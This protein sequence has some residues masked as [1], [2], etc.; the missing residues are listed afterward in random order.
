MKAF[1]LKLTDADL[2]VLL[3]ALISA[4]SD[5]QSAMLN[6]SLCTNNTDTIEQFKKNRN[7][8]IEIMSQLEKQKEQQ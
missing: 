6:E 3:D 4:R 1:T 7:S 2:D 5:W 8:S